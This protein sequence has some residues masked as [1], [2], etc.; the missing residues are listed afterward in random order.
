M[1]YDPIYICHCYDIMANLAASRN[2][3][4]LLINR[5]TTVSEDKHGNLGIRGSGDSS[6]LVSI[7]SKQMMKNICTSQKDI[8][9]SYF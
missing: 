2:D 8:S 3:K 1:V 9:W 7:D 6:I 4:I 5:G